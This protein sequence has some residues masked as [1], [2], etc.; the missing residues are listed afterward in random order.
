MSDLMRLIQTPIKLLPAPATVKAEP[1]AIILADA[2]CPFC[3]PTAD[4]TGKELTPVGIGGIVVAT[5]MILGSFGK[6]LAAYLKM[7]ADEKKKPPKPITPKPKAV[8]PQIE[9]PKLESLS[10]TPEP[11]KP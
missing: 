4:G 2:N 5:V 11:D 6:A 1:R 8:M 9:A 10:K 7:R 3:K